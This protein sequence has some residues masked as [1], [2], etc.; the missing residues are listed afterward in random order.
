MRRAGELGLPA[1]TV[2]QMLAGGIH[3]R[4][5]T[6]RYVYLA[7]FLAVGWVAGLFLLF[8]FG[9]GLSFA[10]LRSARTADPNAAITSRDRA[11]RRIYRFVIN[12]AGVYYYISLPFIA[13][14]ALASVLALLYAVFLLPRI[15][16]KLLVVV[17]G[18]G[19][20]ML[21]MIWSSIKSLFV[22]F[23]QED[24]GAVLSESEAPRLW[25]LAREVAAKVGTRP[26]NV[27]YLTP[28][29]ELAVFERGG[30][31]AKTRDRA[32]R[33]L[34]LGR[35]VIEGFGLD[36]FRAVLAHEY[37]HFLHRDT[38]GGDVA[39]RVNATMSQF[40]MAM[41]QQGSAQWWNIGWQFV[42]LYHLL[43][44][45]I[46]HGASRLHEINADRVAAGVYGKEAFE[47]GLRHVIRRDVSVRYREALA[48]RESG[49][50]TDQQE[51]A[52]ASSHLVPSST[53]AIGPLPE[54]YY[55]QADVRRMIAGDVARLWEVP[56][57]EE[58]TH[59]SPVE[60]IKLLERLRRGESPVQEKE[61]CEIVAER[62]Q[63][64]ADLFGEPGRW[65]ADQNQRHVRTAKN[66]AEARRLY[67]HELIAHID[68]YLAENP[69][70]SVPVRDRAGVRLK[71]NDCAGAVVDFTEA[72][73]LEAPEPRL[74]HLGRGIALARLGKLDEA[75]ADLRE[76]MRLDPSLESEKADGLIELG[77]VLFRAG[78]PAP[79]SAN[80]PAP[81]ARARSPE[82]LAPQGRRLC[83]S[84]R[85]HL[86]ARRLW[87]GTRA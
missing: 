18:F 15:P 75:A 35:E 29:T 11:L 31:L 72:I 19:L 45:R 50:Q 63:T 27:I 37:G 58:D 38:A 5:S 68:A 23:N 78:R 86:G 30:W 42:R 74:C 24:P 53:S 70:L 71:A 66:L 79:P 85:L 48:G 17:F 13:L 46:T 25:E 43:F 60:R 1:E 81:S 22:K 9:K 6:W 47:E 56:T 61:C 73:R 20:A 52:T 7:V 80:S 2:S 41:V 10:T 21:M 65:Q 36:P 54:N 69:G 4:A 40:A 33:S 3:S 16:A 12:L 49:D 84:R 39:M 67:F 59:P 83:L 62:W 51:E 14:L 76:A 57:S 8:V 26:V 32:K 34:I 28:G 64:V 87:Q 55:V 77:T 82:Y 44:R